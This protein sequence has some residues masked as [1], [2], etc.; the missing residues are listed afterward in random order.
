MCRRAGRKK[1]SQGNYVGPD[2][3]LQ[4]DRGDRA[5]EHIAILT[6]QQAIAGIGMDTFSTANKRAFSTIESPRSTE[7]VLR[8]DSN[9]AACCRQNSPI[10]TGRE[11]RPEPERPHRINLSDVSAKSVLSARRCRKAE[12]RT[13]RVRIPWRHGSRTAVLLPESVQQR[14]SA[15][16]HPNY[17]APQEWWWRGAFFAIGQPQ[18]SR[19]QNSATLLAPARSVVI[20]QGTLVQSGPIEA[21][22]MRREK[23]RSVP[24]TTLQRR[25]H[26]PACYGRCVLRKLDV[27][28]GFT[29]IEAASAVRFP[30]TASTPMRNQVPPLW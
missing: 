24:D 17:V 19:W 1:S 29:V 30:L 2:Q 4:P 7:F 27:A 22:R 6:S 21:L 23:W 16:P 13:A 11:L 20:R 28:L 26:K 18:F 25:S 14:P 5:P 10:P 3:L 9:R 15:R 12:L 8:C